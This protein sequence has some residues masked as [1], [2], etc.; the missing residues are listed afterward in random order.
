M[1]GNN[2]NNEQPVNTTYQ[3]TASEEVREIPP[4]GSAPQVNPNPNAGTYNTGYYQQTTANTS[5]YN[6]D[7]TVNGTKNNE[8]TPTMSIVGLILGIIGLLSSCCCG[9]GII[10]GIVGWILSAKGQQEKKTGIGTAGIVL[11]IITVV[12]SVIV[13]AVCAILIAS[14]DSLEAVMNEVAAEGYNY[15]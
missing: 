10:F 4:Y 3:E 7:G 1:D 12:I 14:G 2:L 9:G 8:S 15:Y 6:P 5:Y 11:S 13:L